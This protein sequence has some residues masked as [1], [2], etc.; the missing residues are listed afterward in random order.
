MYS[1]F[2]AEFKTQNIHKKLFQKTCSFSNDSFLGTTLYKDKFF[3]SGRRK[4]NYETLND[5]NN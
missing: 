3:P 5:Y 2:Y 4:K 1:K